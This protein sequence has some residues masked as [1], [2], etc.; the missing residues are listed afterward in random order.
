MKSYTLDIKVGDKVEVGRF[1]NVMT[2]VRAIEIDE[3]GQPVI[4]TSEADI[5]TTFYYDKFLVMNLVKD[6]EYFNVR[7]Q[8]KPFMIWIW[9]S[10]ILIVIGGLLNLCKRSYEK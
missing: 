4:I 9:V 3:H 7:Y 6:N 2:T 1:R 5:K 8:V 10:T